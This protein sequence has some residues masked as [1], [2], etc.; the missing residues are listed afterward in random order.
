MHKVHHSRDPELTD[1]NFG[2]VT[3]LWDRLFF[4][5]TAAARGADIDYGLDGFDARWDQSTLGLL[6]SP[7]RRR[8]DIASDLV[9]GNP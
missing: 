2:N 9:E 4:T 7:W 3:S 8:D 1:R 5:Y 6:V